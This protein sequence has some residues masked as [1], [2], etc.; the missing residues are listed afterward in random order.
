M[1]DFIEIYKLVASV[2]DCDFRSDEFLN[3]S[4]LDEESDEESEN[5]NDDL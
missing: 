5:S 2:P 1:I 4:D 3:D